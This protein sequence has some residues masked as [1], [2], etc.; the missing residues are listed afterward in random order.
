MTVV[1][2]QDIYNGLIARGVP[3]N[4]AAAAVGNFHVESGLDTGII[5]DKGTSAGLAQ[6]HAERLDDLKSQA[7]KKGV[8]WRDPNHQLDYFVNDI[9]SRPEGK[10]LLDPNT[11]YGNAS[12]T[13]LTQYERPL[14][15]NATAQQRFAAGADLA[16]NPGQFSIP[17]WGTQKEPIN[18]SGMIVQNQDV[19]PPTLPTKVADK[20]DSPQKTLEKSLSLLQMVQQ[21]VAQQQQSQL[22]SFI[23][24]QAINNQQNSGNQQ[25]LLNLIFGNRRTI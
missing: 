17:N 14:D 6:W 5:G 1:T 22:Q 20:T 15:P 25:S 9:K 11:S 7:Q 8:D 10:V 13:I 23:A 12:N 3:P 21:P 16:N 24:P 19:P 4:T 2:K 18:S